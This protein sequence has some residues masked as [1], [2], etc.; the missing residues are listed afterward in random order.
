MPAA[1]DTIPFGVGERLRYHMDFSFVRA[2]LSEMS[3]IGVDT[4]NGRTSFHFRSRVRSTPTI[5]LLY[6]VRDEIDAWFDTERLFTHRYE[7][8][9]QEGSYSSLKFFDYDHTTGWVSISNEYGP[10]GI[11]PFLPYSHNII[12]ALYWVRSQPLKEGED[13][14]LPL[15]D[16]NTQYPLVVK[17]YG[18]ETITVPAGTFRCWKVEPVLE[19][20]GLFQMAGRLIV[21]LSDDENRIPVMMSSKIPV[22]NIEGKL[23]DYRLGQPFNPDVPSPHPKQDDDWDW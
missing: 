5:D 22:G 6:K 2:G 4:I 13:L 17:V 18:K 21:W 3:I 11:T 7:R 12:S 10:K 15:H 8:R 14:T 19:S 23:V 9:I 20:E 16:M 1:P